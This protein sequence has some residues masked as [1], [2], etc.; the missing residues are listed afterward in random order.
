M[1]GMRC[2]GC[3]RAIRKDVDVLYRTID[4]VAVG[5]HGKKCEDFYN[6]NPRCGGKVGRNRQCVLTDGH[7]G[8]CR[9]RF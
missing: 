2:V 6:E 3:G 4:D 9:G 1:L 7:P 8:S 5:L